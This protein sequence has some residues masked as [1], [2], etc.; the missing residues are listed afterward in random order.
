VGKT[1]NLITLFFN[2]AQLFYITGTLHVKEFRSQNSPNQDS[3][4]R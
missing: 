2:L 1:E 3:N 4:L